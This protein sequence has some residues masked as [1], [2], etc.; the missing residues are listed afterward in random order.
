MLRSHLRRLATDSLAGAPVF[1][2]G[3]R[4]SVLRALGVHAGPGTI[5]RSRCRFVGT[6]VSFGADCW[7]NTAVTFDAS[8]PVAIADRV[9]IGP[10][11]MI[12]T[13]SHELGDSHQRA[14]ARRLAPVRIGSGCWLGARVTVLPGVT[15]GSGCM[16]AAGSVV[17][18]DCAA[19][20]LYAGVPAR[21][22]R[23]L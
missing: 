11:V 9:T 13:S 7:V 8:A 16:I 12:I 3:A 18:S 4:T 1:P 22:I 10:E 14:R 6:D 20:G 17:A 21:R 5:L 2:G 19:D 23:D 15:I